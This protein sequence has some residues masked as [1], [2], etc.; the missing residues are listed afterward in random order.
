MISKN[1]QLVD[2]ASLYIMKSDTNEV[3][4]LAVTTT[5]SRSIGGHWIGSSQINWDIFGNEKE[6][7]FH[8]EMLTSL[9]LNV[10]NL[11]WTGFDL[12]YHMANS[13][14]ME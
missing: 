13:L 1:E 8:S 12:D 3:E 4:W 11:E 2:F 10:K 5:S 7:K 9:Q 6:L 14:E